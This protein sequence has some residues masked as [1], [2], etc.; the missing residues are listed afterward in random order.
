MEAVLEVWDRDPAGIHISEGRHVDACAEA[1]GALTGVPAGRVAFASNTSDA[2]NIAAATVLNRWR[3]PAG[4]RRTSS[5][6]RS[7]TRRAPMRG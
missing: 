7:R 6:T 4:P 1:V 5:C 2:L 3:Q